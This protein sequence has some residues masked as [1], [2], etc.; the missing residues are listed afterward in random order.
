[1]IRET[2]KGGIVVVTRHEKAVAYVVSAERMEALMETRELLANPEFVRAV[3]A[4]R[5]GKMK[6]KELNLAADTE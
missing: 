4:D 6:F 2:E 1:M 3:K 5:A